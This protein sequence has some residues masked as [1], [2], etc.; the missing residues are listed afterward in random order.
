MALRIAV[1]AIEAWLLADTEG[2]ADFIGVSRRRVPH[3]PEALDDPKRSLV[4]LARSS[5]RREIREDFVPRDGSGRRVGPAYTARM[6][7]FA[8][9]R[10]RLNE[11]AQR[12]PSLRRSLEAVQRLVEAAS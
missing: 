9:I 11:A 8:S 6:I 1:R 10:W 7:E 5:R 3:D 12:S 4:E 2:I